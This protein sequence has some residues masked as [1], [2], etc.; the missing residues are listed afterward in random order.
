MKVLLGV[1]ILAVAS[2]GAVAQQTAPKALT[3]LVA[4]TEK[5]VKGA[6][7]SCEAVS[8]SFQTLPDGN[9]ITRT[10]SNK[11]FR[12]SL[13]RFRREGLANPGATLGAYFELQPT[14]LILDPVDGFKY[15]VNLDSRTVKKVAFRMPAVIKATSSGTYIYGQ[16]QA[17]ASAEDYAAA[18]R[19]LETAAKAAQD[20][21]N[22]AVVRTAVRQ[23][24]LERVV[25]TT[26][27]EGR[28]VSGQL[29]IAGGVTGTVGLNG[30][31]TYT[32]STKTEELGVQTIEG[33]QAEGKR[34][35]TT[36]PAGAIG[37]EKPIDIVYE[38]WFS[39]DLDMIVSSKHSDPRFGDQVY[40]L[41]N[42]TRAEPASSLFTVPADFKVVFDQGFGTPGARSPMSAPRPTQ[43][44]PGLPPAPQPAPKPKIII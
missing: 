25:T 34:T 38:R 31:R 13:G 30:G 21:A 20:E 6:P 18:A 36:I 44:T 35:I 43:P 17:A 10:T 28:S 11:M 23:A 22:A 39:K 15:Y 9:R 33:L 40:R 14:I 4:S 19:K 5:V 8:E 7:F 2:L 41:T 37:N 29:A 27:G 1:L 42:I 16:G 26:T 32:T 24:E 12:D 3:E